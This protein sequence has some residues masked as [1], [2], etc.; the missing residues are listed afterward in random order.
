MA[1]IIVT[2]PA[3]FTG[4]IGKAAFSKG[5]GE[6]DVPTLVAYFERHPD[7]FEVHHD[8]K[9][10][11]DKPKRTRSRKPKADAPEAAPEAPAEPA[12]DVTPAED[13]DTQ[14]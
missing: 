7:R 3:G 14:E 10:E 5:V 9:P 4:H 6:T 8:P 2:K 11:A 13:P 12:E 1:R